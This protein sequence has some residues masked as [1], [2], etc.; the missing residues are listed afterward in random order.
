VW[1]RVALF[2]GGV[3]VGIL[4]T[5]AWLLI[6]DSW[7]VY[8]VRPYSQLARDGQTRCVITRLMGPSNNYAEIRCPRWSLP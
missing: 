3:A 1:Q 7:Y 8:S 6:S 5:V 4:L 2:L